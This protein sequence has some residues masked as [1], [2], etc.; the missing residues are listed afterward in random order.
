M[1]QIINT[2]DVGL[3]DRMSIEAINIAK[4]RTQP[5]N[6]NEMIELSQEFRNIITNPILIFEGKT[7]GGPS[8]LLSKLTIRADN[9]APR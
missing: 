8:R 2:L 3:I 4:T 1:T 5:A 9:P 7:A 6:A